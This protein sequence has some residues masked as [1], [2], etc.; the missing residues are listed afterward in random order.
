MPTFVSKPLR[1][2]VRA[3]HAK[4]ATRVRLPQGSRSRIP[5]SEAHP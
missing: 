4:N 5:E 2:K 3:T 1:S